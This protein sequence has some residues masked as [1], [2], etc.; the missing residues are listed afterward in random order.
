MADFPRTIEVRSFHYV[1][2]SRNF[3]LTKTI[4]AKAALVCEEVGKQKAPECS[5]WQ[6]QQTRPES[7]IVRMRVPGASSISVNVTFAYGGLSFPSERKLGGNKCLK[8]FV[9][10]F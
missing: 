9:T 6:R 2:L 4:F 3:R 10:L 7:H 8:D 5:Q 1:F